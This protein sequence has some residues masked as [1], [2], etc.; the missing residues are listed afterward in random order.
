MNACDYGRVRRV[1]ESDL[2]LAVI[3]HHVNLQ[4]QPKTSL[5]TFEQDQPV[6]L[7]GPKLSAVR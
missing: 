2:G 4:D 7:R 5:V 6:I 3:A 1:R